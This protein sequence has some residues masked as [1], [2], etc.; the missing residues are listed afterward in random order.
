MDFETEINGN[1]LEY[2]DDGHIYLV[3]GIIVPSI[4]QVLKYKFGHK[5]DHVNRDV[6]SEAAR[7]GTAVHEAIEKYCKT[8]EESDL[9]ELRN[10]KFLAKK[11]GFEAVD[12]EVPVILSIDNEPIAAGRLD[13]VL[14]MD[15]KI[16]GADIKRTATLD[17]ESVSLQL[18][19]YRIAYRQCYGIE[20]EFLRAIHLREDTR[21]FVTLPID[22][23]YTLKFLEEY[24]KEAT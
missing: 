15:G 5:Y 8:G 17:K 23:K 11:Y 24:M 12:N 4:T 20:W 7:K 13:M 2:I 18:N 10:Y 6:L 14:K 21:K 1:Y 22:E 9:L 16:G 3:N 19:L